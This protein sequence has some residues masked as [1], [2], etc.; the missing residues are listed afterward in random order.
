LKRPVADVK[1][2]ALAIDLLKVQGDKV[3]FTRSGQS[4]KYTL[5]MKNFT[6]ESREAITKAVKDLP[7]PLPALKVENAII[8]KRTR[9]RGRS[10]YMETQ[11]IYGK[12]R[13]KNTSRDENYDPCDVTVILFGQDQRRTD[14]YKV[15]SNQK[16]K[17]E[18]EAERTS[19]HE[20]ESAFTEF[21]SDNKGHGNIGGF[22]YCGYIIVIK[23]EEGRTI[24]HKVQG[25]G[26]RRALQNNISIIDELDVFKENTL[27]DKTFDSDPKK[28]KR[29]RV[30]RY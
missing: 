23:D 4:K 3:T 24:D 20:L 17:S 28:I 6:E 11:E 14:L 21:D 18:P 22:A 19:E 27:L 30:T 5:P 10:Y 15:L 25:S 8:G 13:I 12:V 9:D 2:R 16:F 1:G 29:I 26:P 7:K